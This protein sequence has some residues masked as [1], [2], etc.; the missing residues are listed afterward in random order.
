M[1]KDSSANL[2]KAT[3]GAGCFWGVEKVFSALPGV[4]STEAGYIGGTLKNPTYE[5]VSTGRTGHA[6]AVEIVYD[7]SRISFGDLVEVFFRHH[8][9]TTLNQQ[10]NDIGTQYRSAIFYHTPAQKEAAEKAKDLLTKAKVFGSPIVTDITPATPFYRAEEYHQKY[11]RKNPNG[12]CHLLLQSTKI[13]E[14]LQ[15]SP[16]T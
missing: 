4:T 5:Q 8:D 13:H 14:V 12:Y 7:P 3:F 11:L 9:P 2:E 10:G 6:E 1:G 16:T 15:G